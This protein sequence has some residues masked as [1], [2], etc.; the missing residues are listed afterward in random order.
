MICKILGIIENNG[1]VDEN[2]LIILSS[3]IVGTKDRNNYQTYAFD[4]N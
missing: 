3:Y 4:I 2:D 1:R